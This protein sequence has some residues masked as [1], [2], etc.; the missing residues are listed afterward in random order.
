MCTEIS[1]ECDCHAKAGRDVILAKLVE[2]L[3][4][5]PVFESALF[6]QPDVETEHTL[7]KFGRTLGLAFSSL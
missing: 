2:G 6:E 4:F 5:S 3:D 7:G 1:C